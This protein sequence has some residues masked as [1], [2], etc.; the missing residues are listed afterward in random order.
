[1]RVEDGEGRKWTQ[2]DWGEIRV[3]QRAFACIC[4][5]RANTA[6]GYIR[7]YTYTCTYACTYHTPPGAQKLVISRKVLMKTKRNSTNPL[8]A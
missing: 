1:M 8:S 7:V 2:V 5:L 4:A 3:L 6:V